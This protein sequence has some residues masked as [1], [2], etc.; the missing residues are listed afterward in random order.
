MEGLTRLPMAQTDAAC[1]WRQRTLKSAIDCVGV[2]VHSGR[3]VKLVIRP[4]ASNHG[5]VFHRTD[6]NRTITARFENVVGTRLCTVI[7]DP[8]MQSARVGTIE[9]LMA[10]LSAMR[11]DNALIELDGPEVPILDGSAAPFVFL[12]DC[13]GSIEQDAPR[14]VI[15]VCRTVR[16]AMGDA[17]AELQPLAPLNRAA[18]P[19]LEMEVSIDFAAPAIGQQSASLQVSPNR[20][21]EHI[22]AARTFTQ[23]QE[24][25]ELQ[26][27]G[28]A[29]L[30]AEHWSLEKLR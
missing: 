21:R 13:A 27:A 14:R 15:E 11:I 16:V 23:A 17:W 20:F 30:E 19:A 1:A 7:A 29:R 25:I 8:G 6:L 9:H 22:A 3:R 10:A 26:A 12:L 2:G 18:Q 24:V 28:L 4:A 5:L